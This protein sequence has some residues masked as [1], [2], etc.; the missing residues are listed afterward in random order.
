MYSYNSFL[1]GAMHEPGCANCY[2]LHFSINITWYYCIPYFI[3][4]YKI[5]VINSYMY[6]MAPNFRGR[7][8][9]Y[10]TLYLNKTKFQDKIFMN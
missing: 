3:H 9:L 7:K 2:M 8:I 4:L 5:N 10:K 1:E 6:S